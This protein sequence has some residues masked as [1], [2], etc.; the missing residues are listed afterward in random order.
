MSGRTCGLVGMNDD[1]EEEANGG[2]GSG[3]EVDTYEKKKVTCAPCPNIVLS[4]FFAKGKA[5][6]SPQKQPHNSSTFFLPPPLSISSLSLSLLL[7]I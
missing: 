6:L 4:W 3:F 1:D 2:G 5:Q 7:G